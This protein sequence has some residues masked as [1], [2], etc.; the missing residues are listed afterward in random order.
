MRI[1]ICVCVPMPCQVIVT[2]DVDG[3]SV[4]LTLLSIAFQVSTD[5]LEV[6]TVFLDVWLIPVPTLL[7][8]GKRM[9]RTDNS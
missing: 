9:F 1:Y 2:E 7:Q 6:G 8:C 3:G 5:A 4:V